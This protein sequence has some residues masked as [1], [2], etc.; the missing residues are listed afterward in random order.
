MQHAWVMRATKFR[1]DVLLVA[2]TKSRR[3]KRRKCFIVLGAVFAG[4]LSARVQQPTKIP[5]IGI[6]PRRV[7]GFRPCRAAPPTREEWF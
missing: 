2:T 3:M 7:L 5:T 1:R 4:S 6:C